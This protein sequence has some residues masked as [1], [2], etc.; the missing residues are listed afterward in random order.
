MKKPLLKIISAML[1]LTLWILLVACAAETEISAVNT[2]DIPLMI[3][4]S[5]DDWFYHYVMTGLRFGLIED[6]G[7]GHFEPDRNVTRAEFITMLGRLHEY[8]NETIGTPGVGEIY[9][10]YLDWAVETGLTQS[11]V[12]GD[13]MPNAYINREQMAMIVFRY[14]E[15]FE[16]RAYFA[17]YWG[18]GMALFSDYREMSHDAVGPIE[19]LRGRLLVHGAPGHY[20]RPRDNA[21]RAEALEILARICSAVYDLKHPM[22]H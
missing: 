15:A 18:V 6:V 9:T 2:E 12:H 14:I 5:P 20:F 19:F 13:L 22:G 10:R 4:V 17:S 11:N 16:L 7:D 1:I 3:D 21:T 8:G